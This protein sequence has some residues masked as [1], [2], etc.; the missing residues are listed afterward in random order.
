MNSKCDYKYVYKFDN[1]VMQPYII[2][3][4]ELFFNKGRVL[5]LVAC[6]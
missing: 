1:D 3:S 2:D 4:S 6:P 5:E